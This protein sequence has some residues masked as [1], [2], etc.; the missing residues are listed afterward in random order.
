[1]A[2][3]TR[4]GGGVWAAYVVGWPLA[5]K[6]RVW[7]VGTSTYRDIKAPGAKEVAITPGLSGR[8]WVAWNDNNSVKAV[9]SNKAVSRFGAVR[10]AAG[11]SAKAYG[12]I[13][14]I[15][16]NGAKGPLDVVVNADVPGMTYQA[17]YHTQM[18]APL[19]VKLSRTSVHSSSGG[20]VTV[21]VTEAGAA[22][23][24]ARVTFG[25]VSVRTNSH[26]RAV[27]KVKK[28]AGKGKKVVTVS[29]TYYVTTRATIKVT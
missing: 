24:G 6:I 13:Y 22:V 18:Y 1:V 26:G 25:G 23:P 12:S 27:V 4:P 28:H 29:L 14:K 10:T 8:L 17:L 7:K 11:P 5:T 16:I 9:R 15:A 19:S 2:L 21:T 20:S 3:A